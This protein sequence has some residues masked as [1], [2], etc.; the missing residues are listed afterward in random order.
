M[1]IT[2]NYWNENDVKQTT[3]GTTSASVELA[4]GSNYKSNNAVGIFLDYTKGDESYLEINI[5]YKNQHGSDYF[6]G[7][8]WNSGVVTVQT[9]QV[10]ATKK[11]Y[12]PIPLDDLIK[13]VKIEFTL[14]GGTTGT[15]SADIEHVK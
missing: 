5:L 15:V 7:S 9:L 3:T 2:L 14:S 13:Y 6:Y 11:H 4:I 10:S 1:S 8:Y 12:I